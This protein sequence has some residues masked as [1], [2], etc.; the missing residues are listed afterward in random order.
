MEDSRLVTGKARIVS[1]GWDR[2]KERKR[3]GLCFQNPRD[4]VVRSGTSPMLLGANEAQ[5]TF[6]IG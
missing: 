1:E 6:R 4:G 5:S 2:K 3:S